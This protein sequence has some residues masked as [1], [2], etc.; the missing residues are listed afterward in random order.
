MTEQ[1]ANFAITS[2][3][4]SI[5]AYQTKITVADPS[6]F[7]LLGNFHIVVQS[8]DITTQIPVSSPELMLVTAVNG[9]Q[10]TV[11]R[12]IENTAPIAFASGAQVACIVTAGVMQALQSGGGGSSGTV[13]AVNTFP[14]TATAQAGLTIYTL[15]AASSAVT[16]NLPA[17]PAANEI[18]NVVDAGNTSGTGLITI[19]GNGNPIVAYG[20]SGSSIGINSNGGSISLAWDGT[21]WV[22]YA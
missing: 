21:N 20:T 10:F 11:T 22:S 13:T 4:S 15:Y 19:S 5:S 12:G 7:P 2:L 1:F 16:F 3:A 8:F 6:R 14:Y 9:K 17:I 18:A